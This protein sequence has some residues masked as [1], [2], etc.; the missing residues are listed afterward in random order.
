MDTPHP[1]SPA[2]AR[3]PE[4][5]ACTTLFHDDWKQ[6][7]PTTSMAAVDSPV[8]YLQALCRF[9]LQLEKD[10]KGDRPKITLELR[11]PDLKTLQIDEH[12]LTALI[13]QLTL[14]NQT[15]RQH[16]D[17]YLNNTP[18]ELRGRTRERWD[19]QFIQTQLWSNQYRGLT[20]GEALKLNLLAMNNAYVTHNERL[21]EI[22]KTVSLRQ[23]HDK[24]PLATSG[25][26]WATLKDD[27]VKNGHVCFEL[28]LKLFND[29]YPGHYLPFEY[30]GAA[31]NWKLTF[32][33]HARQRALLESL[34]DIIVQVRYTAKNSGGH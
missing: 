16:L 12:S 26:P 3:A 4:G 14:V 20:A 11:R 22:S 27:L 23:L 8:A 32:P 28:T 10:G 15:L 21:L 19:R 31:S 2:P 7:C 1:A 6:L 17:A 33:H 24:D 30:T 29:D 18:S 34:T 9:A 5:T 25:K 13:P